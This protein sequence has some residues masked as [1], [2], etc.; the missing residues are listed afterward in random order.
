MK[1]NTQ[2]VDLSIIGLKGNVQVN[3]NFARPV[4]KANAT[5]AMN[6]SAVSENQFA[7]LGR[8][9]VQVVGSATIQNQ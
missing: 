7:K 1:S 4:K 6:G 9:P 5:D 3:E 2:G 8:K